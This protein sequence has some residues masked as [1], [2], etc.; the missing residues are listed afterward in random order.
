[1][2][3]SFY[4]EDNIS[5]G[6]MDNIEFIINLLNYSK[7][8]EGMVIKLR[9]EVNELTPEDKEIPYFELHSDIY[10]SFFDYPTVIKY[11]K[12]IEMY[13]DIEDI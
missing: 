13:F 2:C 5:K 6:D 1:M 8:L 12:Y 3:E 9:E 11:Q 7:K 10:E 4:D